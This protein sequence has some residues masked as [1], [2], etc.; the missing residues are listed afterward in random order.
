MWTETSVE[1]WTFTTKTFDTEDDAIAHGGA[2]VRNMKENELT[3]SYEIYK[4]FSDPF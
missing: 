1:G 4:E 2:F 3:R